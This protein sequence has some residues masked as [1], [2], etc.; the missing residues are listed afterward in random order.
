MKS[1][2]RRAREFALQGMYQWLISRG[3]AREIDAHLRSTPGY[4][5]ADHALLEAVLYGSINEAD[6]LSQQLQPYLDRPAAQLSPIEHAAL[7]TGAYELI[8]LQDVPYRVVINEAVEVVKTFGGPDG[9]RFV[10]GVLDKF[11][12]EVRPVE[13]AA[14]RHGGRGKSA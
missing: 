11:A 13:V 14:N 2:R 10:N 9:H 8:H 6:A 5:K 7:I 12:A 1:A 3:H 4:D